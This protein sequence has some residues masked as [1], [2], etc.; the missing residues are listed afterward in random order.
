MTVVRH[1]ER[2]GIVNLD[3]NKVASL[4]EKPLGDTWINGGY[5]VLE[6]QVLDY[7]RSDSTVFELE[8]LN[9]LIKKGQISAYKYNGQYQPMDTLKDKKTLEELWDSGRAYWKIWK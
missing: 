7:I 6:P 2:F 8:P 1:P 9:E 5:Y 4:R 3:G